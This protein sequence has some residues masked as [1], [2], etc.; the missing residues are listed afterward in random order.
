MEPFT[1][2]TFTI[3]RKYLNIQFRAFLSASLETSC[4]K[5]PLRFIIMNSAN[6][7]NSALNSQSNQSSFILENLWKFLHQCFWN[8]EVKIS[9]RCELTIFGWS[10][11][12]WK[13]REVSVYINTLKLSRRCNSGKRQITTLEDGA[14]NKNIINSQKSPAVTISANGPSFYLISAYFC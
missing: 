11:R 2:F 6:Y 12:L 8:A 14:G 10:P 7:K 5:L 1:N 4:T 3:R 13:V 9:E